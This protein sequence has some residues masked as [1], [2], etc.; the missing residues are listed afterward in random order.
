MRK[1]CCV[2]WRQRQ[3]VILPDKKKGQHSLVSSRKRSGTSPSLTNSPMPQEP[4]H[5]SL[6]A[7]LHGSDQASKA[8]PSPA[9]QASSHVTSH[10]MTSCLS[11]SLG[12]SSSVLL[13]YIKCPFLELSSAFP[14]IANSIFH[15]LHESDML[16]LCSR[17]P[18]RYL[19]KINGESCVQ[20][21][22]LGAVSKNNLKFRNYMPSLSFSYVSCLLPIAPLPS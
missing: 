10:K 1:G 20:D 22:I 5:C 13:P 16:S 9:Q 6:P 12:S 2:S 19:D 3:C 11:S 17:W 8:E 15:L 7:A 14:A 18:G 21:R 4:L